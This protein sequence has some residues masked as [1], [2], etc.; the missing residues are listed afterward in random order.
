MGFWSPFGLLVLLWASG[1]PLGFW[2]PFGLLGPFELLGLFTTV[3]CPVLPKVIKICEKI[4]KSEET[5]ETET[6]TKTTE[7]YGIL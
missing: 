5:T 4:S 3:Y 6:E 2:G 7:K 1:A